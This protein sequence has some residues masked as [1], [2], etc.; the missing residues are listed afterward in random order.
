MSK[1]DWTK[2]GCRRLLRV[3]A[4]VER[5]ISSHS[6]PV[7]FMICCTASPDVWDKLIA[8]MKRHGAIYDKGT[9]RLVSEVEDSGNW[10]KVFKHVE[11]YLHSGSP[12]VMYTRKNGCE[13]L[14]GMNNH[15]P[16]CRS[17]G[18]YTY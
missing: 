10:F 9:L 11:L 6:Q 15:Q 3:G 18:V 5:Y 13:E 1:R 7:K 12:C 17:W 8:F 2:V 14:C 4:A 16:G